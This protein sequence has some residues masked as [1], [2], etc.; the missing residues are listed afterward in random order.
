MMIIIII[1]CSKKLVDGLA[2]LSHMP[3]INFK[4]MKKLFLLLPLFFFTTLGCIFSEKEEV[5][6][7]GNLLEGFEFHSP[8]MLEPI[9]LNLSEYPYE[10]IISEV[11]NE[12]FKRKLED[13]LEKKDQG[14]Y[15]FGV[16]LTLLKESNEMVIRPI[17][18]YIS[19]SESG[20]CG[21]GGGW[22]FLASCSSEECVASTMTLAGEEARTP[23]L[24]QSLE[25]RLKRTFFGVN[26]CSRTI[27]C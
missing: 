6:F 21:T 24:G 10:K 5:T 15:F 13:S 16:D 25:F 9:T 19:T 4:T 14:E 3:F 22:Q 27:S 2:A 7:E 1:I 8:G 23:P 18:G 12:I 11:S 20:D 26:V 17:S